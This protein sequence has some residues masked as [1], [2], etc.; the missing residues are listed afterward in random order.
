MLLAS[1]PPDM[2]IPFHHDTGEWVNKTHRVHVPVITD[3]TKVLFRCGGGSEGQMKRVKCDE[4]R[5]FEMNNQAKHAVSNHWDSYRVHLILDYVDEGFKVNER[6]RL[7]KGEELVQTRRSIDRKKDY[8]KRETP[9]YLIIGAQKAGTTSMYEYI[10]QHPL[11]VKGRRRETHFFDWRWQDNLKTKKE[12]KEFYD[13]FF[14]ANELKQVRGE[15][16]GAKGC[17]VGWAGR[18]GYRRLALPLERLRSGLVIVAS[19]LLLLTPS[20]VASLLP[21]LSPLSQC[22]SCLTGD[23]TPSYLLHSDIVIPRV[24]DVCP[25]VKLIVMLRNPIDRAL[26]HYRMVTSDDGTDAQKKI[27]GMAWRGLTFEQVIEMEMVE[28][29]KKGL[30]GEDAG[31]QEWEG[32]IKGLPMGTGSHSL[33]GRGIYYL[34]LKAWMKEFEKDR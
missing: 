18:A 23:S 12:Q 9:S 21:L 29:E 27:R 16:S 32:Y 34:Q 30:M 8:G 19:L 14:F 22:P 15:R 7:G 2:T 17:I 20:V 28:M 1:M 26:S 25:W 11:S 6:V 13:K 10:N 4:G 24:K 3:H 33:L 31:E 5:V